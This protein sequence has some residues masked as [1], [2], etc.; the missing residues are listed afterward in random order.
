MLKYLNISWLN[1]TA[2]AIR[3][4]FRDV[5]KGYIVIKFILYRIVRAIFTDELTHV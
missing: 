2:H 4:S 1:Q 5:G 3:M